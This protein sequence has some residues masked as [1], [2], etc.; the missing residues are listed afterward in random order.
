[1]DKHFQVNYQLKSP[2]S[3]QPPYPHCVEKGEKPIL[4]QVLAPAPIF[5]G[6]GW[7]WGE[8][9]FNDALLTKTP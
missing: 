2:L 8:N 1:M 4:G 7:G 5:W 6:G 9:T 3:P